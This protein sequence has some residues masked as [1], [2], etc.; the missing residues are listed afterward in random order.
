MKTAYICSPYRGKTE[1]AVAEHTA[2]AVTLMEYLL[3]TG[4][5]APIV[6]H[7]YFPQVLDDSWESDREIALRCG[8]HFLKKCD[9]MVAGCRYGISEGMHMEIMIALEEGIPIIWIDAPP[10]ML[11]G[12]ADRMQQAEKKNS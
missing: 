2:Y 11:V 3:T 9:V 12:I 8:Q 1:E 4:E 6:P 7:L 10:K 5:Y